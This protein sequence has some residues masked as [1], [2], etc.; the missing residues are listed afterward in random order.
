[1]AG[2]TCS[3]YDGYAIHSFSIPHCINKSAH[4]EEEEKKNKKAKKAKAKNE[5]WRSKGM[6]E[7]RESQRKETTT[8]MINDKKRNLCCSYSLPAFPLFSFRCYLIS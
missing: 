6:S 5:K 7:K 1:M 8:N 2:S 4:K 3:I